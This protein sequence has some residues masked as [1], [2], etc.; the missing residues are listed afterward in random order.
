MLYK[1]RNGWSVLPSTGP[2]FFEET[3]ALAERDGIEVWATDRVFGFS[4]YVN[5]LHSTQSW[6]WHVLKSQILIKIVILF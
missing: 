2:R 5:Q 3:L 1:R 4:E 6:F